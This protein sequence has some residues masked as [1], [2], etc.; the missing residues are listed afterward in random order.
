MAVSF[1]AGVRVLVAV[2]RSSYI[3]QSSLDCS[4]IHNP[5]VCASCDVVASARTG[6]CFAIPAAA[7]L[8][9]SIRAAD[10]RVSVVWWCCPPNPSELLAYNASFVRDD[11]KEFMDRPDGAED[12][13]GSHGEGGGREPGPVRRQESNGEGG[14]DT[15]A[16]G[17]GGGARGGGRSQRAPAR[18]R[19][20]RR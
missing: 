5:R 3:L 10:R 4:R 14:S 1:L 11:R 7:P 19:Y 20:Y 12:R 17:G 2:D 16:R 6:V 9:F 15:G 8:A 18:W 13:R